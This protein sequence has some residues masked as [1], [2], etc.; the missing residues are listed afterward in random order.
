MY[1]KWKEEHYNEEFSEAQKGK[2]SKPH[3]PHKHKEYPQEWIDQ[4]KVLGQKDWCSKYTNQPNLYQRF[5]K[6]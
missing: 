6:M 1:L 5:K 4:A 3:K 2:H